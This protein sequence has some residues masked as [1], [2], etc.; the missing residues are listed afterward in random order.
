MPARSWSRCW[1]KSLAG[2]CSLTWKNYQGF[3]LEAYGLTLKPRIEL[4]LAFLKSMN[5]KLKRNGPHPATEFLIIGK[6]IKLINRWTK[7]FFALSAN[8]SFSQNT[9]DL[10]IIWRILG[11]RKTKNRWKITNKLLI[12]NTRKYNQVQY[13]LRGENKSTMQKPLG[14]HC[15]LNFERISVF[16]EYFK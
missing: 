1:I 15:V 11:G 2:S 5:L 14:P 7:F 16:S 12:M 13:E 9:S 4:N 10:Q 3:C 8:W 6:N